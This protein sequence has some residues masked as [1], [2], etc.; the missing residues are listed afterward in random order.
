MTTGETVKV[1]ST[2]GTELNVINKS[3][4]TRATVNPL[5]P[6]CVAQIRDMASTIQIQPSP[7][8]TITSSQREIYQNNSVLRLYDPLFST[9]V[10]RTWYGSININ[11]FMTTTS[12]QIRCYNRYRSECIK[13][14][15]SKTITSTLS[16]LPCYINWQLASFITRWGNCGRALPNKTNT[17]TLTSEVGLPGEPDSLLGT[18]KYPK[19]GLLR[20]LYLDPKALL[21]SQSGSL[22]IIFMGW[23]LKDF[24]DKWSDITKDTLVFSTVQGTC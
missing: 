20:P 9:E 2:R 14:H 24:V 18:Q 15:S 4:N 21:P 19:D 7:F 17:G 10:G 5:D 3:A 1:L 13:E 16:V 6:R 22:Q 12:T 11:H 8:R 23:R